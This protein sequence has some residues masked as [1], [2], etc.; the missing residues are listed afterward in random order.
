MKL[1]LRVREK[2]ICLVSLHPLQRHTN[3]KTSNLALVL[4]FEHCLMAYLVIENNIPG[5]RIPKECLSEE[6][7]VKGGL[8]WGPATKQTGWRWPTN[9]HVNWLL[10]VIS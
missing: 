7:G 6:F 10:N 9:P 2:W 3:S 4:M 8:F 1:S 5:L